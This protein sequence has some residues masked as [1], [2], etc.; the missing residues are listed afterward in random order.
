MEAQSERLSNTSFAVFGF[1][2]KRAGIFAAMGAVDDPASKSMVSGSYMG[3]GPCTKA[4]DAKNS[5]D[6][7]RIEDAACNK[8]ALGCGLA[9]AELPAVNSTTPTLATGEGCVQDGVLLVDI[10]GDSKLEAFAL[11]SLLD[12]ARDPAAEWSAQT[13]AAASAACKKQFSSWGLVIGR[14]DGKTGTLG[15]GKD[16][17][18]DVF[19]NILGIV[20]LNAD[21]RLDIVA[22]L[23][24]P[25]SRSVVVYSAKSSST[26]LELAAEAS[27]RP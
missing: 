17:N 18:D 11:E 14:S 19:L 7:T 2:G 3:S 9:V 26:S 12:G 22:S 16:S 25:T 8:A 4:L 15:D 5:T 23:R 10:D 20:D 6:G 21:G 24:Y 13:G 27:G 1:D